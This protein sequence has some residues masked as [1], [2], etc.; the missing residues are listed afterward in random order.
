MIIYLR[1]ILRKNKIKAIIVKLI[2]DQNTLYIQEIQ[3]LETS[4]IT[5]KQI[6]N[7]MKK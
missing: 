5:T 2:K 3:A 7:I 4:A 6:T 1:K